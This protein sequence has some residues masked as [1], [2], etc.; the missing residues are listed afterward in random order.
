MKRASVI[1]LLT[2]DDFRFASSRC[3]PISSG[4]TPLSMYK[5]LIEFH[6]A[7]KLSFKYVKTFNMDEY[8]GIPRDHPESYHS[9]MW[10]NF[11]SH[12]DINPAHVNIP[13]GN[14]LDLQQECDQYEEKI[15]AAGGV[16]LFIGGVACTNVIAVWNGV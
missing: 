8:V 14:A 16:D 4:S 3:C 10:H 6:E 9:F 7:G 12:I 1:Q 2:N 5:K 13:D 15:K 11:F